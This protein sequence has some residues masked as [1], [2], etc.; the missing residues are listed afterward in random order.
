MIR[1]IGGVQRRYLGEC[2]TR[3][4]WRFDNVVMRFGNRFTKYALRIVIIPW[5]HRTTVTNH[6]NYTTSYICVR[7]KYGKRVIKSR[8]SKIVQE[9]RSHLLLCFKDYHYFS[10]TLKDNPYLYLT[11]STRVKT[12]LHKSYEIRFYESKVEYNIV[13]QRFIE[14]R[15]GGVLNIKNLEYCGNYWS[16]NIPW[17]FINLVVINDKTQ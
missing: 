13:T 2:R 7:V 15:V 8:R 12:K 11:V 6:I 16:T 10:P 4:G 3:K 5:V 17:K 14:L 9:W 1:P